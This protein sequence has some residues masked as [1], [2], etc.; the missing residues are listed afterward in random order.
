ML[1]F[2]FIISIFGTYDISAKETLV[3]YM[4]EE[5]SYELPGFFIKTVR[6]FT[7]QNYSICAWLY[8][9]QIRQTN[10]PIIVFSDEVEQYLTYRNLGN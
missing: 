9:D 6:D 7:V 2:I 4:S 5:A 1:L 8:L 10:S 3:L